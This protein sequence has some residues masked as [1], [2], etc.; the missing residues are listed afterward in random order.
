MGYSI[1][2]VNG[3]GEKVPAKRRFNMDGEFTFSPHEVI[4]YAQSCWDEQGDEVKRPE[5][6][7]AAVAY[8]INIGAPF[9]DE[10]IDEAVELHGYVP[11]F[12]ADGSFKVEYDEQDLLRGWIYSLSKD[13]GLRRHQSLCPHSW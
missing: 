2:D 10:E 5:E 3:A 7:E 12:E 9:Y 8:L 11:D 4:L 1:H 6:I 13:G